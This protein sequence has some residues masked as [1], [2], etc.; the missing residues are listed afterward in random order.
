VAA[1]LLALL[2][3]M[4]WMVRHH[5]DP[6]ASNPPGKV[7]LY[8]AQWC[9]LCAQ[10]RDCFQRSGLAFEERDVE[11]SLGASAQWWALG[12]RG[13]PATLVGPQLVY[14]FQTQALTRALR[15]AGHEVACWE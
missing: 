14:G 10:L 15:E 13:V 9:G 5:L 4:D 11:Q 8:S 3:L 7:V 2:L 12:V 1:A 6:R